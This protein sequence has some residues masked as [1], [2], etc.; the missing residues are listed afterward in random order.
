MCV[1][2]C[3]CVY[4]CIYTFDL[5]YMSHVV[6]DRSRCDYI[7][8]ISAHVHFDYLADR[9]R[10]WWMVRWWKSV[11]SIQR[12]HVLLASVPFRS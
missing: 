6:V 1:S 3:L 7:R 11:S 5:L 8:H 12:V 2:V 4:I 10:R 9:W